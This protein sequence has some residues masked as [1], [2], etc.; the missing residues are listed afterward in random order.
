MVC[1]AD[2][3][4]HSS[5]LGLVLAQYLAID[6]KISI[7]SIGFISSLILINTRRNEYYNLIINTLTV[8][9][10]AIAML[11]VSFSPDSY[12]FRQI[13][14]GD[15]LAITNKDLI[16]LYIYIPI[17]LFIMAF[18]WRE[19]LMMSINHNL[20]STYGL[21]VKRLQVEMMM[22]LVIFISNMISMCGILLSASLLF[23]PSFI[24]FM[25]CKDEFF[26]K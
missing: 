7:I 3:I 13:V 18:R 24:L 6:Y 9:Y 15:I 14:I 19:W 2:S 1:F 23:F 17:M 21:N 16:S 5:L 8:I 10:I 20:A 22:V 12:D 25:S 11:I 26:F 4:S